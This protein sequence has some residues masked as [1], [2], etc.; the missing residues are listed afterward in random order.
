MGMESRI[1]LHFDVTRG[2]IG[3]ATQAAQL[4]LSNSFGRLSLFSEAATFDTGKT[5][6]DLS[7]DQYPS[8]Y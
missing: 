2:K 8:R 4:A 5:Q 3:I 1:Q 6:G 7:I